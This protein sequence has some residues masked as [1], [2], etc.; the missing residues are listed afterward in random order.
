MIWANGYGGGSSSGISRGINASQFIVSL[1][2]WNAE[3]GTHA[4]RVGTFIHELGHNL[5]LTHGGTDHVKY[6]PNYL[7]VM[8]YSFQTWGLYKD[9][10]W[11]DD[12]YPLNFD[13]QRV[14][15]PILNENALNEYNGLSGADD[16]SSYGTLY[17]WYNS[18][19]GYYYRIFA[20]SVDQIDWDY[21]GYIESSV[22]SDINL[23]GSRTALASQNNWQNI[24]F[25]GGGVIGSGASL[26]NLVAMSMVV[27]P[28]PECMTHEVLLEMEKHTRR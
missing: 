21:D 3:G 12:G 4:E 13:Y 1:G 25:N 16:L 7:S 6:K 27:K 9:G 14:N 18:S 19:D 10:H 8:N 15:T 20:S 5:N 23:N 28:I 22:Y 26:S 2:L 11:G 24:S 17:Y